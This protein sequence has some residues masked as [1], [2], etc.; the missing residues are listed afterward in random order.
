MAFE[1]V[2]KKC[3]QDVKELARALEKMMDRLYQAMVR[4]I[5]FQR[6]MILQ[7]LKR[8]D[9]LHSLK[10]QPYNIF[11]KDENGQFH[12]A[13]LQELKGGE[14]VQFQLL[15]PTNPQ[16]VEVDNIQVFKDPT[17]GEMVVG[18]DNTLITTVSMDEIEQARDELTKE[19]GEN[20]FTLEQAIAADHYQDAS[21]FELMDPENSPYLDNTLGIEDLGLDSLDG[22]DMGMEIDGLELDGMSMDGFDMGE[23]AENV[24][25]EFTSQGLMDYMS[26]GMDGFDMGQQAMGDIGDMDLSMDDMDIGMEIGA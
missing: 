6:Q 3:D 18:D 2:G 1:D 5:N 15:D 9:E 10:D 23:I 4:E 25:F 22:I 14:D 12:Q 26:Q 24:E 11:V 19:L 21:F 17:S 13:S 7:E 8:Q 20:G 16:I